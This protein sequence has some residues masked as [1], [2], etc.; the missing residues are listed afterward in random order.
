MSQD[1]GENLAIVFSSFGVPS[2]VA[3]CEEWPI[4]ALS[5]GEALI[6]V[7]AAPINPADLNV[8]EGKYGTL[9]ALPAVPGVEGVGRILRVE[10]GPG[11]IVPGNRVILPRGSGT[12]RR[13]V[14]AKTVDL[15]TVPESVPVQQAAMLRINPAT[16]YGMLHH[17]C[18]LA[19]GEWVMQNAANSGVGR[20]VIQIARAC[21]LRTVNVVRRESLR[22]ELEA[23]GADVVLLEGEG[24]SRRI[25]EAT[26]GVG[27]RLGFNGVGGESAL[28]LAN[29]LAEGGTLV[30]YGAMARQPLRV[31]NGLLIFRD[32]RFCGFWVTRW[33][34][35]MSEATRAE[36]FQRLIGWAESGVLSTPVEAEYPLE[37]I[38]DALLHAQRPERWGKVLLRP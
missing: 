1:A 6:E 7:E 35:V 5:A 21:G 8:L 34:D 37:R 20:S 14:V 19:A 10:G 2:D 15:I 18:T 16:A 11:A 9:P 13:R 22:A 32:V 24:L 36:L 12:W 33:Y 25:R 26:G 38:R 29:A 3:H 28:A 23:I 4:P 27:P 31:P 17:F 30:T